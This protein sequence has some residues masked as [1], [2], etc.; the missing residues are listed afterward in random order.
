MVLPHPTTKIEWQYI[1]Q[2]WCNLKA[3]PT[4]LH[5]EPTSFTEHNNYTTTYLD[6][7]QYVVCVM[8]T[9]VQSDKLPGFYT[10]I[11]LN[12]W[13]TFIYLNLI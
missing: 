2:Q 4:C 12:F 13:I 7:A 3:E 6:L 1:A 8:F 10:Q 5:Y 9:R 11:A